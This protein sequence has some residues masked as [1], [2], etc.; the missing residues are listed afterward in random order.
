MTMMTRKDDSNDHDDNYD[1]SD[2][3]DNEIM[4]I[5]TDKYYNDN[6]IYIYELNTH[7]FFF[8]L[9]FFSSWNSRDTKILHI[10]FHWIIPLPALLLHNTIR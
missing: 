5:M 6:D 2:D 1:H 4:T 10:F 9:C 3:D 8:F 7:I